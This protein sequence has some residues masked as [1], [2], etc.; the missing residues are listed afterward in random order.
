MFIQEIFIE[1]LIYPRTLTGTEYTQVKATKTISM[2][3]KHTV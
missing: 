2:P 1:H 3:M